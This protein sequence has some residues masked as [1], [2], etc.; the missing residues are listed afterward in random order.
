VKHRTWCKIG[1]IIA[2]LLVT[3]VEAAKPT[4]VSADEIATL[5]PFPEELALDVG[6]DAS[7]EVMIRDV[8]NLFG[9]QMM[10]EFDPALLAVQDADTS[11]EEVQIELGDFVSPDWILKNEVDV[12]NGVIQ[13]AVCSRAPSRPAGGDGVLA[14]VTWQGLAAGTSDIALSD[15]L[16]STPRGESIPVQTEA[17]QVTVGRRG[18]AVAT[19]MGA[20]EEAKKADSEPPDDAE[21]DATARADQERSTPQD[22]EGGASEGE[23][24][25]GPSPTVS[26]GGPDGTDDVLPATPEP[27]ELDTGLTDIPSNYEASQQEAPLQDRDEAEASDESSAGVS[28]DLPERSTPTSSPLS[29]QESVEDDS[30]AGG[31]AAGTAASPQEE[32]LNDQLTRHERLLVILSALI[33]G[34]GIVMIGRAA[35]RLK[36]PQKWE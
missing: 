1:I 3:V 24:D 31:D 7:M 19:P 35:A 33:A 32:E 8:S 12:E 29:P 27:T 28:D 4:R 5:R 21:P 14:T 22:D 26:Q 36:G 23:M 15:V 2:C 25:Q 17:A 6:E 11:S 20:T 30:D 10:I 34:A 16:L 9:F 18:Q 13:L